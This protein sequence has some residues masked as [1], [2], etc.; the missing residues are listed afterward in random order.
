MKHMRKIFA[1]A[2]AVLM[3]MSLSTT[4]FATDADL[5]D[6]TYKAYQIFAGTQAGDKA[7]LGNVTWGSGIDSA[8]FLA[9]LKE[10]TI[11]SI[12]AECE[13]AADVAEAITSWVD[14]S[15]NAMAFAKVAYSYIVASEGT[16]CQNGTTP[17]DAGY[18]LV[19]DETSFGQN[20]TNTVYNLALLQL[21][22]KGTF[23]IANKTDV[24]EFQKKVKDANDTEGTISDWQDSADHDI[25]DAVPFQLKATLANNVESYATYKVVFHD[26]LSDGLTFDKDSVKVYVG[27][28]RVTSGY[29]VNYTVNTKCTDG[30]TF[31]VVINNAKAIGA[32]NSSVITVEYTAELNTNAV[33]GSAGNPNVANLE[34]SNNPN[35]IPEYTDDDNN[36]DTPDVPKNP[37]DSP[38]GETPK[39]KVIVFTYKVVVNKVD[40]S[41]QPL[42]GAEFTLEKKTLKNAAVKDNPETAEDETAE[43]VYEWKAIA[44]VKNEAGTGFTF[45]GLDDGDYRLT[46]TTTPAG[47]NTIDPIY[48]TVTADHDDIWEVQDRLEVL[49]SL[50]GNATTGE[51]TFTSKLPDGYLSADVVNQSGVE[52]PET[53]GMGT[54]ILYSIG[55]M[56]ALG[57]AV[58]LITK[59]RMNSAE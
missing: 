24:P 5:R 44:V 3:V 55:A 2:L 46:E 19:V 26:T 20:A 14:K 33:L 40:G 56:L 37:E 51:L 13:T 45:S 9:A 53:G 25:G 18:Y 50:T 17:L 6:H 16:A 7:N 48:F 42:T 36:P 30:C 32:T 23:E 27:G 29:T 38:T 58:L 41:Q 22:Q 21:T 10:S 15:D 59:K 28:T 52:L 54:T 4:A 47:Y 11:G 39:D 1:M 35:W 12:F 49:N 43:A 34:Y 8:N 57:A 31:E